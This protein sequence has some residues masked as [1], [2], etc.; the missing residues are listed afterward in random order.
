MN[1]KA[2]YRS[3][4]MKPEMNNCQDYSY[5]ERVNILPQYTGAKTGVRLISGTS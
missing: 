3:D 2:I 1:G 4:S 5:N